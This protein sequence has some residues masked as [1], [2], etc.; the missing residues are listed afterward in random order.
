MQSLW[1]R[2]PLETSPLDSR[3]P[4]R[5]KADSTLLNFVRF[6]SEETVSLLVDTVGGLWAR[7]IH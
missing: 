7:R 2:E 3:V 1:G 6:V 4:A 5:K